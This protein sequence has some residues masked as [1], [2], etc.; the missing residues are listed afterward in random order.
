MY[1]RG[2]SAFH[3]V[4]QAKEWCITINFKHDL[5]C[6]PLIPI[7]YSGRALKELFMCYS[8]SFGGNSQCN[9]GC[10][11]MGCIAVKKIVVVKMLKNATKIKI[12]YLNLVNNNADAP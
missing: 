6:R 7:V 10:T 1:V 9:S 5:C 2:M 11:P 12:M 8:S 4:S 3:Y